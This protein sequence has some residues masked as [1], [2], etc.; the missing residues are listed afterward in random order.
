MKVPAPVSEATFVP[1]RTVAGGASGAIARAP[2]PVAAA[3]DAGA[4]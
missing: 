4:D 3:A 1:T 2:L